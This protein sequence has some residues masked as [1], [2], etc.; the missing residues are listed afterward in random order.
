MGSNGRN[1]PPKMMLDIFSASD[2]LDMIRYRLELHQPITYKTI[3]LEANVTHTGKPKPL[4]VR[5]ALT[6]G[7]IAR[8]NVVLMN[9]PFTV[10]EIAQTRCNSRKCKTVLEDR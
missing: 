9:V 10:A 2:E 8:H 3:I 1:D 7:E 4:Y 6:A 5:E